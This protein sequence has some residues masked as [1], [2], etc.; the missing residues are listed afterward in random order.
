MEIGEGRGESS[1]DVGWVTCMLFVSRLFTEATPGDTWAAGVVV[2]VAPELAPLTGCV[3][4]LCGGDNNTDDP[5][6]NVSTKR[7]TQ[8]KVRKRQLSKQL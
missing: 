8:K 7:E 3:A 1:G 2:V 6:F 5:L 4:L